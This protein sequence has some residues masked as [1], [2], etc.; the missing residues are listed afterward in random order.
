M[1]M[2]ECVCVCVRACVFVCVG[3]FLYPAEGAN[4]LKRI[5]IMREREWVWVCVCVVWVYVH[6]WVFVLHTDA[7]YFLPALRLSA[8]PQFYLVNME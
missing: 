1:Y 3:L 2:S 5:K 4:I 6:A 7:C 8:T